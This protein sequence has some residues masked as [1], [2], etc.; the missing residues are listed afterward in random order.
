VIDDWYG[1]ATMAV[2]ASV[3]AIDHATVARYM[4]TSGSTGMPK[5][6]IYTQGMMCA[7]LAQSA[8]LN[9][10]D[11]PP[12]AREPARVLEWMPWSHTGAGVM[13][14][15]SMIDGGGSIYFDTG[16]PIPGEYGE[17]LRNLRE[18][19][20]T[21][22][23]GAPVGYV[24]L[25]DALEKDEDLNRLVLG[26]VTAIQ[27]GS[28]AMAPAL[29]ERLQALSV[30]A[31][32]SRIGIVSSLASTEVLG[33]LSVYWPMQEPGNIGL[34]VPGIEVKLV[35]NAG[36]LEI[37]VKGNAV[38]P[39]YLGDPD[40]SAA[41]FDQEG[42]FLMG[43]AVRFLDPARPDRG[44]A[45]DGRIAEQFKLVT[46]TWVSAGTLRTQVVTATSPL[47][48]DAVICGLNQ[49]YVAV[50]LWPNLPACAELLGLDPAAAMQQVLASPVLVE[51]VREGLARHNAV[52]QGS[53]AR[54]ERFTLLEE[55][56]SVEGHEITEKGYVNQRATLERR[57]VIVERLYAGSEESGVHIV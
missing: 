25:A 56:P 24:M 37:R 8:G 45:F 39:G 7:Q 47:I 16:R 22:L 2:D 53:S 3:Q 11:V 27:F 9:R 12:G 13:R 30:K 35:P 57:S 41:R 15:N 10:P 44:L 54:I 32:G 26:S 46:G 34:P 1:A 55:P 29:F 38:T 49:P 4:F 42:F 48:R 19:R 43:D 31:T 5:G 17:T 33:C 36:R 51:A 21:V 14:L 23:S 20:P 18:V 50:M 6:V 52:Q 40:K 28:A